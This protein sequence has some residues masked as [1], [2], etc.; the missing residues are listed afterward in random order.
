VP[1]GLDAHRSFAGYDLTIATGEPADPRA[2]TIS[3]GALR[4]TGVV[5]AASFDPATGVLTAPRDAIA[6]LARLATGAGLVD[7]ERLDAT[8][9]AAGAGTAREPHPRLAQGLLALQR[10]IVGIVLGKTGYGMPG[11]IGE[12]VSAMHVFRRGDDD[13]LVSMPADRMAHFLVWLLD[14]GPRPAPNARPRPR[15]TATR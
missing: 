8:F 12:T 11:W 2:T 3:V 7:E 9:G 15:S 6:D 13:Q 14:I 5:T 4:D 10:S 1:E